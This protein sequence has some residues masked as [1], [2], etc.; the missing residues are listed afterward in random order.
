MLSLPSPHQQSL[1]ERVAACPTFRATIADYYSLV[2][3]ATKALGATTEE[4]RHG[5]Y[6]R[7]RAAFISEMHKLA[8][9][10]DRSEIMTE[11]LYLELAIGEVEAEQREPCARSA[12]ASP[13]IAFPLGGELAASRPAARDTW[14]TELL[15]RASR[16]IVQ[17]DDQDYV[18]KR[19]LRRSG[20]RN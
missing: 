14:L 20:S 3:K 2:A 19:G 10:L 16:E 11:Q 18:P 7:A 13:L 4:A 8:P 5:V 12:E 17:N 9:A 6:D 15:A 1:R